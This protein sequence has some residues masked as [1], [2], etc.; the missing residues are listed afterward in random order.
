MPEADVTARV[1]VIARVM[2]GPAP[3]SQS[4]VALHRDGQFDTTQNPVVLMSSAV[5][6][7]EPD[8]GDCI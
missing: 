5:E 7:T 6:L 2:V 4:I 1:A 8:R 3:P